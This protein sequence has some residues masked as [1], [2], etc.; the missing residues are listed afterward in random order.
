MVGFRGAAL[1]SILWDKDEN[2]V[3]CVRVVRLGSVEVE[4]GRV[5]LFCYPKRLRL[6]S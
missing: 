3:G 4:R 2:R 5:G 6:P 1:I